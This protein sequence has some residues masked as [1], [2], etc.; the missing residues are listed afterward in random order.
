MK[1]FLLA[2]LFALYTFPG[3]SQQKTIKYLTVWFERKVD[4]QADQYYHLM[5]A[6]VGNY[7]PPEIL[8]LA[9]YKSGTDLKN[10]NIFF[11]HQKND[12]AKYF[13]NYFSNP[14]AALEYLGK[15]GWQLVS[16]ANEVNSDHKLVYG[17]RDETPVTTITAL[18]KYYLKK[19]SD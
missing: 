4:Y 9:I 13:Y 7:Y 2:A 16:V 10:K 8:N 1:F 3:F 6:E 15:N 5:L 14:T 18:A 11:Y 17:S 12:T 19:E